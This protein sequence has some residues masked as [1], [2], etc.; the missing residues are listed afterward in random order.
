[1]LRLHRILLTAAAAL[2]FVGIVGCG[3]DNEKASGVNKPG[4]AA[5]NAPKSQEEYYQQQQKNN[6]YS[7]G[8][9]YPGV[10]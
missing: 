7:K 10:K 6:P 1:M 4:V 8:G 2:G 3:E 5:S 9:G